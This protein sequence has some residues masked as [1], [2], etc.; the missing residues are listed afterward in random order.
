M[1][2]PEQPGAW[3]IGN[4]GLCIGQAQVGLCIHRPGPGCG[5]N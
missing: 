5:H 1:F 4:H 3:P 2:W